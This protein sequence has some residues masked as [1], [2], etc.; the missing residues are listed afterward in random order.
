MFDE[1]GFPEVQIVG[2]NELDE[3]L[4]QSIRSEGGKI[5][6]YGVGTKLATCSGEGGGAL[7][8]VYKLVRFDEEPKLKVTSDIAK[9]T[10]P[11]RK[12]VLRVVGREGRFLMDVLALQGDEPHSG[13]T[14]FDPTNPARHKKL[15]ADAE[16]RDLRSVVMD[17]GK[18]TAARSSLDEMAD[19]CADQLKRLPDGSLRLFNPHTYKVSMTKNLHD[20]RSRL[21]DR[22]EPTG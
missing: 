3:Y 20:L 9:A 21:M 1:A 4:I 12:R 10:L 14:V 15:P 22:Y 7:G 2:S 8:G 13:D 11:D 16:F 18:I 17:K 6:I 5:D 19:R